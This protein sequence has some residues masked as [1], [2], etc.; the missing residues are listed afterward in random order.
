MRVQP[1]LCCPYPPPPPFSTESSSRNKIRAKVAGKGG[2]RSVAAGDALSPSANKKSKTSSARKATDK[3][4]GAAERA[5]EPPDSSLSDA[6]LAE[7]EIKINRSPVMVLWAT[8]RVS[9]HSARGVWLGFGVLY[10][11]LHTASGL[12]SAG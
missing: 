2:K 10:T 4:A 9:D 6:K 7:I 11:V 8:V 3:H 1:L 12:F 5:P